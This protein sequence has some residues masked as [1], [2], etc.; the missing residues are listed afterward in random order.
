[1][2]DIATQL[3]EAVEYAPPS[4]PVA[5]GLVGVLL[6]DLFVCAPCVGRIIGRGC[7]HLLRAGTQA[8]DDQLAPEHA[9]PCVT[10]NNP[11]SHGG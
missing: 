4:G 6:G 8:W 1:M 2:T 10:C 7:G 5:P 3:R 9:P 11:Q